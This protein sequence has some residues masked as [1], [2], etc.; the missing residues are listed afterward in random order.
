MCMCAIVIIIHYTIAFIAFKIGTNLVCFLR[1]NYLACFLLVQPINIFDLYMECLVQ[2]C[3]VSSAC[4]SS[5]MCVY[6]ERIRELFVI[7]VL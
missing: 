2:V 5:V 6:V 1:S 7:V 4:P 3:C